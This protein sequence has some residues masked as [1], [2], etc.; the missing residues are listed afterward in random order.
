[1]RENSGLY[2]GSGCKDPTAY[3]VIRMENERER[4]ENRRL[5]KVIECIK[6]IID[7]GGFELTN[8]ISL[9]D[10]ESRREHR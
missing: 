4:A 8:R 2:N 1:M 6:L 10:K 3:D 5:T 9:R 7:L